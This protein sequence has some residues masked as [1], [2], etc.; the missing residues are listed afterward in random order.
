MPSQAFSAASASGTGRQ[1][2]CAATGA[3]G[4]GVKTAA[5]LILEY[6][7]LDSQLARASEVKQTKRRET[8]IAFADQIRR[9]LEG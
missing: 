1:L 5:Q 4:I 3:P 6:G 7:D 8:L 9:V 2:S